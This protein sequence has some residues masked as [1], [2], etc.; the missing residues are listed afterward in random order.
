V[1]RVSPLS[2]AGGGPGNPSPSLSMEHQ[3]EEQQPIRPPVKVVPIKGVYQPPVV[4]PPGCPGRLTN[5]LLLLKGTI[6]KALW[7]HQHA[8]P[9]HQPVDTIKLSLPDYFEI[10]HSPMDMGTIR[11]TKE[12]P[13][14]QLLLVCRRG[15]C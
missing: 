2:V 15:D 12:A 3:E 10:I 1:V 6:M 5:R 7:K 11:N 14:K 8:W 4:P 9:F 13:G